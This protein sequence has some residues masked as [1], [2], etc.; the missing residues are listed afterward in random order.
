VADK[1]VIVAKF[2]FPYEGELAKNLLQNEGVESFLSGE[3]S[4]DALSG[5]AEQVLL[6]VHEHDAQRAAAIL[7]AQQASL[8][9][10]WEEEAEKGSDVWVCSL[11]GA[12]VSNLLSVCVGCQTPREGI[13]ADPPASLTHVRRAPAAPPPPDPVLKRDEIA[14]AAAPAREPAAKARAAEP[15]PAEEESIPETSVGDDMARRALIAAIFGVVGAGASVLLV[16][17][18]I[19]LPLSWYFLA[20]VMFFQG[21]LSRG[22]L[23]RYYLALAISGGGVVLWLGLYAFLRRFY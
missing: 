14:T 1:Y 16:G 6:Q 3:M 15:G 5:I 22:A 23:R 20:R 17:L 11:C 12:P 18:V 13:R 9:E 10:N 8:G 2:T 21:E 19:L 7:A 4:A